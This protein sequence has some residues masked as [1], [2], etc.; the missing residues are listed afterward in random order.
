M[1]QSL[2]TS[3]YQRVKPVGRAFLVGWVLGTVVGI[4]LLG[5]SGNIVF[6]D[7]KS[8]A[9]GALLLATGLIG[10][11]GSILAGRGFENLQEYLDMNTNWSAADSKQTMAK[12]GSV[13]VG[14]MIGGSL[15]LR[16]VLLFTG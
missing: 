12:I 16:L 13:G 15:T 9:V 7:R 11:S 4:V 5:Y 3:L 10:W 2:R 8:F 1:A 6:A 14:W